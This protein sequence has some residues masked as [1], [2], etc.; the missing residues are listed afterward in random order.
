MTA[1]GFRPRASDEAIGVRSIYG[2]RL[3]SAGRTRLPFPRIRAP[4]CGRR[5][6][7]AFASFARGGGSLGKLALELPDE[8]GGVG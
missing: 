7:L 3:I 4:R 8:N 1:E 5:A 6:R 2:P